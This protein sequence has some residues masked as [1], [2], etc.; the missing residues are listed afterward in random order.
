VRATLSRRGGRPLSLQT[1]LYGA[2][3]L[4]GDGLISAYCEGFGM[5][6]WIF[7][8]VSTLG[9]RY[10]HSHVFD[11][12]KQLRFDPGRL[13]VLGDGQRKS[14]LYVQDC[15]DA[16]FHAVILAR[17]KVNVFNLGSKEYCEVN[18]SIDWITGHVGLAPKLEYTGG[19]RG[20]IGDNPFIFLDTARIGA[21]GW[22]PMLSIRDGV[23]RTIAWLTQNEW[24]LDR[25][26]D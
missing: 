20:W 25:R 17:D 1:S 19:T 14:Y 18:D 15:I 5:R 3:K 26:E 24:V 7:R 12:Y 21:L 6:S 23:E 11:F 9:E 4:A 8:F 13:R 22:Q 2:S 10:T 16:M